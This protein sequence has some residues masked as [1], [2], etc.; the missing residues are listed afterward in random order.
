MNAP[1]FGKPKP[2]PTR[3]VIKQLVV[4]MQ[5]IE[6]DRI[7]GDLAPGEDAESDFY[8]VHPECD[9][10]QP[11]DGESLASLLVHRMR[12]QGYEMHFDPDVVREVLRAGL[13]RVDGFLPS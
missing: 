13:S 8:R 11:I 1:K 9:L 6:V 12:V 4:T 7:N 10:S 3:N 5:S 2:A